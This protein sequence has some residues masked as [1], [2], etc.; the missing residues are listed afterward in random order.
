MFEATN[1]GEKISW[2]IWFIRHTKL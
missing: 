1:V 2:V